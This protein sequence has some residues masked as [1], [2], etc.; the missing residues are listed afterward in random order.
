[1][2]FRIYYQDTDAGGVVYYANYLRFMEIARTE[3]LRECG[4]SIE[5]YAAKGILFIVAQAHIDYHTPTRYGDILQIKTKLTQLKRVS[6]VF[7]HQIFNKVKQKLAV[8]AQTKIACINSSGR[9][10]P[11]PP[12]IKLL[13]AP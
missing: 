4:L 6:F 11:F 7:E 3:Y 5:E 1:M 2:E 8:S 12:E 10:T 13:F 9:P